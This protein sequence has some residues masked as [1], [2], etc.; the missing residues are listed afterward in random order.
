MPMAEAL[1]VAELR[2]PCGCRHQVNLAPRVPGL[3]QR[4][5]RTGRAGQ[6]PRP[7]QPRQPVLGLDQSL[8]I[9][10]QHDL[11][12]HERRTPAGGRTSRRD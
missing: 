6:D 10:Q 11:L 7:L 2:D 4:M 3:E 1:Q 12:R 8:L 9:F 5:G